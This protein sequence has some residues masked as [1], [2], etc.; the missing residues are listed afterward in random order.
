ML[1]AAL[2]AAIMWLGLLLLPSR[3]WST[4]EQLEPSASSAI[5]LP[6]ISVLIPARDEAEC[7]GRTLAALAAQGQLGAVYVV[8]DQSSDDTAAIARASEVE[9]LLVIAGSEPPPGW[10]G[11]LWALQQ[12][13][14]RTTTP[15]VL[16]LDADIELAPGMV[17]ALWQRLQSEKLSL[18]SIMARLHMSTFWEK[19]LL[20]PFIYFF[21]LIYPFSLSNQPH[22]RIAAAAGGLILLEKSRLDSIGGFAALHDA[23]IDDCTLARLVKRSGGRTWIGLSQSVSAVRPYAT[24]SNI[25]NM[26]AR[27]AYTQLHYSIALLTL[28]TVLLGL[29]FFVPLLAVLQLSGTPSLIGAGA[30]IAMAITY[31]P[32]VRYYD[33][34]AWWVATLPCAATLFLAMTWTSAIRFWS[35]ERSRWKNRSYERNA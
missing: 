17:A 10:S 14:S 18:V 28:C 35:G 23:I 13:Y 11:K 4:S 27:T 6:D 16:L 3:P 8:D 24:L 7:I 19:L 31:L 22:T 34:P 9:N 32:T 12:A 2:V 26:V 20:P 5:P 21:K 1:T 30:L 15:Y 33:L 29:S 25:W